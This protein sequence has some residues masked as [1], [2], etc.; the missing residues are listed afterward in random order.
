MGFSRKT[1]VVI[2]REEVDIPM[3][4]MLYALYFLNNFFLF[5][6]KKNMFYFCFSFL[7]CDD[8]S[9]NRNRILINQK[10]E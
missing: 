3:H 9:N 6:I 7:F 10:S 8:V 2:M 1:R 4:T 5:F